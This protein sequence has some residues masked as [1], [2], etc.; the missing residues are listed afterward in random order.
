MHGRWRNHPPAV[1]LLVLPAPSPEKPSPTF[2]PKHGFT[3][4]KRMEGMEE[5]FIKGWVHEGE[6]K[7]LFR[8][9]GPWEGK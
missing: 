8:K 4:W 6:L 1:C 5:R 9:F 2:L 7:V 3:V